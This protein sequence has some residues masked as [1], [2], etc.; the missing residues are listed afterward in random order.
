MVTV[1]VER[2][3]RRIR[4]S[5]ALPAIA[6]RGLR[7]VPP[8]MLV[9][10]GIVSVQI[11]AALAKGLFPIAGAIGVVTLRLGF[12]AVILLVAW[13]PSLRMIRRAWLVVIGYGSV[14]GVMNALFYEAISRLPLGIAV[15]VEFLGPLAV[16]VGGSRRWRDGLWVLLAA[17][18]VAL[19]TEGGG[20]I[21]WIGLLCALGAATCWACYILLSAKLGAQ[22]SGGSGL[23]IGMAIG[24]LLILP[25]GVVESGAALVN[26]TALVAGL[27][28]AL[29]SSV[30]PYSVEL[31]ALRRIPPRVFGVL[32]SL[33]PAVAA[34]CGLVVLGQGLRPAQWIA[35][36]LVVG[37][38]VGATRSGSPP[39]AAES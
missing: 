29:L 31:E 30:V 1:H 9:L 21:S 27:G 33:E 14:L 2:T 36:C 16:A 37:A 12:A 11:G 5:A 15:T 39:V 25:L 38:S 35:I 18:G 19:L 7:S 32:M 26:P 28:V 13:R 10:A 24:A 23:A 34:L 8:P 3:S 6:G 17:G 22:T 20:H 4:P